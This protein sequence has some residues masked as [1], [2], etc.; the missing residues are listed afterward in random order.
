M[1]SAVAL[2]VGFEELAPFVAEWGRLETQDERYRQRQTLPMD[3][4]TAYHQSVAPQL[5]A[6]FEHLDHFSF[7]DPLPPP[8]AL[9]RNIVMAMAEVAQ[10]VEVYGRPSIPNVPIGHSVPIRTIQIC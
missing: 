10:A 1:T 2:P 3:R 7:G 8:E 4:L 5:A 9:L 6:I